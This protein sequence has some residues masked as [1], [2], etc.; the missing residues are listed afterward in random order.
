MVRIISE[1]LR[2]MKRSI[3]DP[4][5]MGLNP[6]QVEPKV[7]SQTFNEYKLSGVTIIEFHY[8]YDIR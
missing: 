2:D 5:V 1:H 7:R 6:G 3:P 8:K 4:E